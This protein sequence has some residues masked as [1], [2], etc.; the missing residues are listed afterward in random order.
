[1]TLNRVSCTRTTYLPQ[2]QN[3]TKFHNSQQNDTHQ[4]DTQQNDAQ[5]NDAQLN[6]TQ[7]NITYQLFIITAAQKQ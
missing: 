2:Q 1:M 3:D 6:D 4:N 5:L 7:Q